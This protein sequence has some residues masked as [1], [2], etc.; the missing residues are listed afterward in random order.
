MRAL[1]LARLAARPQWTGEEI[2]ALR[3]LYGELSRIGNNVNQIARAANAAV[4]GGVHPPEQ[5]AL[6]R[7]AAERILAEMDR[8][9]DLV[10]HNGRYW[11]ESYDPNADAK[12]QESRAITDDA[13]ASSTG[14]VQRLNS[15]GYAISDS[16]QAGVRGRGHPSTVPTCATC[17]PWRF[18]S[19]K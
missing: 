1:V 15:G 5:G 13:Q 8:I 16:A 11:D 3:Q 7:A 14:P 4:Q 17:C 6:V 19:S 18:A 10:A 12:G 2:E 9:A